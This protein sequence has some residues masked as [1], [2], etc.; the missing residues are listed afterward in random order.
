VP[1][2]ALGRLASGLLGL[3]FLRVTAG[4]PAL[5][6]KVCASRPFVLESLLLSR[7]TGRVPV[8]LAE[9]VLVLAATASVAVLLR[10]ARDGRRSGRVLPLVSAV[11]SLASWAAI[12]ACFFVVLFGLNYYRPTLLERL[13]WGNGSRLDDAIAAART[14]V[15]LANETYEDAF[16]TTDLGAPSRSREDGATTDAAL[17]ASYGRLASTLPFGAAFGETRGPA[18]PLRLLSPVLCRLGLTGFYFPWTGEANFNDLVLPWERVH[19]IAHEK[20]HQRGVAREDEA[21]FVGA[22]ACLTSE[23]PWLRYAGAFFA[24]NDLLNALARARAPELKDL[25]ALRGP[26]VL[27]DAEAER[28]FWEHYRGPAE[29]V[30]R[31]VNDTYLKS[32]GVR[33]GALSYEESARLLALYFTGVCKDGSCLPREGSRTQRP[34]ASRL[35]RTS[36]SVVA[37]EETLKRIAAR[38]LNVVP[39]Q[40]QV[41][42]D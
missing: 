8:S 19:T 13:G 39:L 30:S 14:A 38:P 26:G 12:A 21:N 23:D 9:G 25:L 5:V 31:A 2:K 33:E 7:A 41:P 29:R 32:Q 37:Q 34:I 3:A 11:L 4:H 20:A 1:L 36:S 42:S 16:G 6:E 24:E 28:A 15:R 22:L 18:K 10:G 35:T 27:R 17:E 40:K